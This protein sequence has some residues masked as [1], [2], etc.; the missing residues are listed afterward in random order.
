MDLP[1]RS[2]V[3]FKLIK[4]WRKSQRMFVSVVVKYEPRSLKVFNPLPNNNFLDWTE[5]KVFAHNKS[6]A[7]KIKISAFDRVQEG[8]ASPVLLQ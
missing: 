4:S 1:K 7:T 3:T 6:N 5:F 2:S 8:H